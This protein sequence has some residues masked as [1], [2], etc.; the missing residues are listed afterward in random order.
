[1]AAESIG[2]ACHQRPDGDAIGSIV[3]LGMSLRLAGKKVTILC[4]DPVPSLLQFLPA[5]EEVIQSPGQGLGFDV[6]V[7]LDNATKVRLGLNTCLAFS[8]A[9]FLINMDHHVTNEKYGDLNYVDASSPAAGQII[10][11]FIQQS[12]LPMN[13]DIRVNLFTAISTDTGSFQYSNTN[14][15]TLRIA[16]EIVEAGVDTSD[17]A[18]RLYQSKSLKQMSLLKE[19][20]NGMQLDCE[21]QLTYWGLTR[22]LSEKMDLLP[23][24]VDD[25]I[26]IL[27]MIDSVKVAIF[28]EELPDGKIRVS[29]R[30]KDP[31]ISVSEICAQFGGGGH[32]MAAG[33]RLTGP[34]AEAQRRFI[35][36][37]K[38]EIQ[39]IG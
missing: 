17:L 5:S 10:Y 31:R 37:T 8:D 11:D 25:L 12:G 2:I 30:S 24:D 19:L 21:N 4:E 34:L 29:S 35:E 27:R 32:K 9:K 18:R 20:L 14:G 33:A 13:D 23:G 3:G 16:A 6:A 39:R 26:D 15:R 28:F 1:M 22:E 36:V 7:A 38:N